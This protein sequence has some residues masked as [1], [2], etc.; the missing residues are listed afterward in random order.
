VSDFEIL[1]PREEKMQESAPG[2]PCIKVLQ[3]WQDADVV[4]LYKYKGDPMDPSNYRGN[5]LLDVAGKVLA[6]V[7]NQRLKVLFEESI[8]DTQCG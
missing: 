6:S 8:K 1:W 5:F 7:I 2:P 4:T 3:Q